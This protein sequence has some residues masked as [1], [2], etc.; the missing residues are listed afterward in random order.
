[1]LR[2][3]VLR[4]PAQAQPQNPRRQIGHPAR[5]QDDE[6]RV[7][8]DQMQAPKGRGRVKRMTATLAQVK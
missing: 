6:T 4:Q 7:V 5:R 8:G 1:M 3:Q 2:L